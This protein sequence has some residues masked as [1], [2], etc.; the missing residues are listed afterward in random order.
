MGADTGTVVDLFERA[1]SDFVSVDLWVR[2][3][4]FMGADARP[5][6]ERAVDSC[7]THFAEGAR[8]WA[9]FREFESDRPER[10]QKLFARQLGIPLQGLP[11]LF[12]EYEAW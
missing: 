6:F 1:L 7:G 2:Y 4:T 5:I 8:L 12:H 10:V 11:D 9:A 3:A